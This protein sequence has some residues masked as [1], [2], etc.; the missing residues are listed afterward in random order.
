M[1]HTPQQYDSH[2]ATAGCGCDHARCYKGWI[3][4]DNNTTMPCMYCREA[5]LTRLTRATQAKNK[6]YP[7]EAQARIMMKTKL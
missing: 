7:Q 6:G 5:T 2:C 3:D 1:Q 4:S